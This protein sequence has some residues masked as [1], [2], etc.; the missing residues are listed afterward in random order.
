MLTKENSV[1]TARLYRHRNGGLYRVIGVSPAPA[2]AQKGGWIEIGVSRYRATDSIKAGEN[3]VFYRPDESNPQSDTDRRYIRP[4]RT[5]F[6]SGRFVPV[7][8]SA[9]EP[10]DGPG[11]A[12]DS[13]V[14]AIERLCG[15]MS[16]RL[17]N[18]SVRSE[19]AFKEGRS[20]VDP[21]HPA[22][23]AELDEARAALVSAMTR[24]GIVDGS[25]Q[26]GAPSEQHA[27]TDADQDSGNDDQAFAEGFGQGEAATAAHVMQFI[28]QGEAYTAFPETL[29]ALR[30]RILHLRVA[31]ATPTP[32]ADERPSENVSVFFPELGE[33]LSEAGGTRPPDS[34]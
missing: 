31:A 12:Q 34:E 15:A 6:E 13:L 21:P 33:R 19:R 9:A 2:S 22:L 23:A 29:N 7:V 28:E 17:W 5:F 18:D 1:E 27:S 16:N 3:V 26:R 4:V 10:A 30:E 32:P 20:Q 14:A 25:P 11:A 24:Y 8:E